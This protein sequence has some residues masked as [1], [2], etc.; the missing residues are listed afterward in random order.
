MGA[1]CKLREGGRASLKSLWS[2]IAKEREEEV[3]EEKETFEV[4]R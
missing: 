1:E 3:F 2:E 4:R